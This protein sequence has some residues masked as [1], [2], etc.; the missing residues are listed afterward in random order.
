MSVDQV[1]NSNLWTPGEKAVVKWQFRKFGHFFT[2]LFG[3]MARADEEN[4]TKLALGFPDEVAGFREWAHGNLAER[5]RK[6][7]LEI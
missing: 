2:A 7:G 5:L 3:T 1:L 6:A 4:L